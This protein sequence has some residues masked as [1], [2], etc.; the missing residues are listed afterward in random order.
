[1]KPTIESE[2]PT[3]GT[4]KIAY[5]TKNEANIARAM[6]VESR[7]NYQ[8]GIK[9]I[10]NELETGSCKDIKNI[11]VREKFNFNENNFIAKKV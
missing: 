1:M 2:K 10:S 11:S 5:Q 6:F 9:M 4:L 8:S 7:E 3:H